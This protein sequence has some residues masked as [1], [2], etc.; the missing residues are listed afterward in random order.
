MEDNYD[1]AG[2][3]L[4]DSD[5]YTLDLRL[6]EKTKTALSMIILL[7]LMIQMMMIFRKIGRPPTRYQKQQ[8]TQGKHNNKR[9]NT[10]TLTI[11]GSNITEE[12]DLTI[13]KNGRPV[14]RN[15]T[16][17]MTKGYIDHGDPTFP[18][19]SC[20]ALLWHAETL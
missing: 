15:N 12:V 2:E 5:T 4:Y 17:Q 3:D 14:T 20:G 1:E 6:M 11:I 9:N 13:R 10:E 16:Q 19:E 8:M 7:I 18:C